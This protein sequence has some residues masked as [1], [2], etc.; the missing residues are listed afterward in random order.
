MSIIALH[1]IVALL[2][3]LL[4]LKGHVVAARGALVALNENAARR[5]VVS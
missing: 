1:R 2:R 4:K 3:V 5:L